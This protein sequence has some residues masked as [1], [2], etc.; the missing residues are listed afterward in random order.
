[1]ATSKARRLAHPVSRADAPPKRGIEAFIRDRSQSERDD[2]RKR[3]MFAL[4][5]E[6][7]RLLH[8][9][10]STTEVAEMLG[11]S[12]Q[13]PH[14]RVKSKTLLAIEDNGQLRFPL[15]QFDAAGPN[16]VVEG[17]PDVLRALAAG[18]LAQARWLT[19]AS[20]VFDG[21]TPL[22]AL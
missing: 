2:L 8:D 21:K 14:D 9:S 17:L 4:F 5:E 19:T 18:A 7:K 11:T 3:A 10:L 1:M 13:T 12:R 15:W 22:D 6:R 16:G 20:P